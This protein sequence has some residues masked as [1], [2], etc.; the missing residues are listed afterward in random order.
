MRIGIVGFGNFGQ[1]LSETFVL[2]G[3]EVYA[4]DKD[5]FQNKEVASTVGIE[6][7]Y[8][9]GDVDSFAKLPL[10]VIVLSVSILSF[11]TVLEHLPSELYIDR[12]VVDVLSVKT[13]AKENMLS[14][15]P[16]KC[17]ILCTHPGFGPISGGGA[18]GWKDQLVY[19]ESIRVSNKTRE[20]EFLN[21][22]SAEGCNLVDIP[23]DIH[24]RMA[25]RSQFAAHLIGRIAA[26]STTSVDADALRTNSHQMMADLC[27][28]TS[29]DSS[30]LFIGMYKHNVHSRQVL[31]DVK[32][33]LLTIE[34]RLTEQGV[35]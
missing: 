20:Q 15:L 1:F 13:F 3:H 34:E 30:D 4:I 5:Y 2:R 33:A 9:W 16:P 27:Q 19:Y 14:F 23:S 21:I 26:A 32:A 24:D 8:E 35:C 7:F 28:A 17:D 29:Q 22:F 25:A 18:N 11:R 12:L 6:S 10:D 31:E